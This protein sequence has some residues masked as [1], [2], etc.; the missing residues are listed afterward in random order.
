MSGD[1]IVHVN[2]VRLCVETFGEPR[3]P[4]ALLIGGAGSS[5]DWWEDGF[6][7]RLAVGLRLVIRFDS[8][9]TGRS[10][11]YPPGTPPYTVADLAADA[12][13]LLDRLAVD[14]AHIVGISMG[15]AIGQRL[16]IEHADRVA[17]LTLISTSPPVRVGLPTPTCRRCPASC[18]PSSRRTDRRRTGPTAPR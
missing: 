11:S 15:G 18:E 8:R 5:M 2:G 14:R 10:T 16:A 7:S 17:S 3:D 4:A 6:C 13:G 9:D 12:V 1:R